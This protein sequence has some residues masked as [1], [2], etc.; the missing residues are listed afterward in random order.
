MGQLKK[1]IY[2]LRYDLKTKFFYSTFLILLLFVLGFELFTFSILKNYQYN[3]VKSLLQS[4]AKISSELYQQVNSGYPLADNVLMERFSFIRNTSGHIQLLDNNGIVIYDNLGSSEIGQE[5][6]LSDVT[7][8][9]ENRVSSL[10]HKDRDTGEKLLTLSYP[11]VDRQAQV[12]LIRL[13]SSLEETD[14]QIIS[15]F[16]IFIILGTIAIIG[17]AI[18]SMINSKKL[19]RPISKLT[20]TASKYSDGQYEAK[21]NIG[22][23]GEIGELAKTMDNMSTNI[24][25]KEAMKADFIS[26]VSH[27]LRTPLTSIKGWSITLQDDDI[28]KDLIIEGLQIIEQESDRLSDMVEDLL[29]FSRFTS[30]NFKL[31]K[32]TFN[33][34]DNA[35]V[36]VKQLRP[37]VKDKDINL[38]LNYS[39]ENIEIIADENRIKQVF[40][41][42]L[43]NAI[44]FTPR[45]GTVALNIQEEE[46]NLVCEVID[47]GIGIPEDEIEKVTAKFFKG[48]GSES[49]T[50]LGL[51][52]C[53]EIV[54]A[55]DGELEIKSQEG[56]G[57]QIK[58]TIP[59]KVIEWK[60]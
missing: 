2:N 27:E 19:F 43:D 57:T 16:S 29:D 12:G 5:I 51:S 10:I 4:E 47:T 26:S 24:L 48:S 31:T 20:E 8:G 50:G 53:E 28:D 17:G 1:L 54:K 39:D 35:K 44:K 59:K 56:K 36:I 14:R 15:K 41:N 11:L 21:S 13:S 33:V 3:N 34:V 7:N 42:L 32:S 49:H 38:I 30:P 6:T 40:I 46:R 52:I 55:H 60:K 25:E 45:E 23:F 22:Y 37:R 18:I 58:F 9:L